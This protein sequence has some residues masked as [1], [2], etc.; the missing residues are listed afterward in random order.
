MPCRL[1][2]SGNWIQEGRTCGWKAIAGPG[3]LGSELSRK[4]MATN[5]IQGVVGRPLAAKP[6]L[7]A[8]TRLP[9]TLALLPCRVTPMVS[10]LKQ[11]ALAHLESLKDSPKA[12]TAGGGCLASLLL[13]PPLLFWFRAVLPA[14]GLHSG[15]HALAVSST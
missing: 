1:C 7:S 6:V 11:E 15:V 9:L 13:P 5:S 10:I 3:C 8:L 12:S 14:D 4:G 2:F